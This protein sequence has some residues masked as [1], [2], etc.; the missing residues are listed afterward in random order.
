MISHFLSICH[1]SS[2]FFYFSTHFPGGWQ[3]CRVILNGRA[4]TP[5]LISVIFLVLNPSLSL[6]QHTHSQIDIGLRSGVC[7][8]WQSALTVRSS[9]PTSLPDGHGVSTTP[10][11]HMTLPVSFQLPP[12]PPAPCYRVGNCKWSERCLVQNF[13]LALTWQWLQ[14]RGSWRKLIYVQGAWRRVWRGQNSNNNYIT[15]DNRLKNVVPLVTGIVWIF[16]CEIV[17]LS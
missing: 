13:S 17:C 3:I 14:F 9:A 11:A 10:F 15:D 6:S 12:T 1:C 7:I 16:L 2:G 8:R 4:N 5:L